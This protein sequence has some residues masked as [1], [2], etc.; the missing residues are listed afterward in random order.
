MKTKFPLY[1][2][3]LFWFFLNLLLLVAVF[4]FV[5]RAQ[6]RFGLDSLVAGQ[7][8]ER[9]QSLTRLITAELRESPREEWDATLKR[10][11]NAYALEFLLVRNDGMQIAGAPMDLPPEV[12]DRIRERRGP[13][14][15]QRRFLNESHPRFG[16]PP[17]F[18]PGRPMPEPQ[19]IEPPPQPGPPPPQTSM[20][21]TSQPSR[22]WVFSRLFLNEAD[23]PRPMPVTLVAMSKTLSAGGLF[24]DFTPWIAA[25]I[26]VILISV[27]FW[28][29]LV[30]GITRSIS[31]ITNATER[32]AEG[33]FDIRIEDKRQDELGLLGDAV[34]RMA[35]RLSGFVGGQRKFLGDIAHELCSPIARMQMALGIL[36]Q[37]LKS[38]TDPH[39]EDLREEVEH[40][41]NLVNELLSFSKASL[42]KTK[43]KIQPVALRPLVE[44]AV[45]R[46][47]GL[48]DGANIQV[49]VPEDL[50]ALA[51]PELLLRSV[52]NIL[53]NAIRYAGD[54][55]PIT[56][57]ATRENEEAI[58]TIEDCGAGIPDEA[59]AQIFDPFY[60]IDS[61]RSRDTGGVGLGLSIVKTCIESCGGTVSCENR[62]PNG[63][64]VEIKIP[65]SKN[66]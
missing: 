9:I 24:F 12:L 15:L 34:N 41:S 49:N 53:R 36:E 3:I 48:D 45:D 33:Q 54:A 2:K 46:E 11:G 57:S 56:I 64:R 28:F 1:A 60:R 21:H 62:K 30:R 5:G 39:L 43:I 37:R 19:P 22:Y 4:Y 8:G 58:L 50:E 27:A 65:L 51:E 59:I 32:I 26:A 40:M 17:P 18:A 66:E 38:E 7:A 42:G 52:A 14:G 13:V 44:K 47:A 61:S 10:F 55:G 25:T 35:T 29:P 63:L 16:E 6:L 31:R 23:L 20:L